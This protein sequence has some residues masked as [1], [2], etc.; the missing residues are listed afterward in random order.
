MTR[1]CA[2]VE[3]SVRVAGVVVMVVWRVGCIAM[4]CCGRLYTRNLALDS[5]VAVPW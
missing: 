3:C 4:C 5:F 2:G 1:G